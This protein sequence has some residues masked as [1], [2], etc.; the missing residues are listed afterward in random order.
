MRWMLIPAVI[1]L[2]F[3]FGGCASGSTGETVT[4][5][6][7]GNVTEIAFQ[8]ETEK[9]SEISS[10]EMSQTEVE[11]ASESDSE[12]GT[13]KAA[14]EDAESPEG[15]ATETEADTGSSSEEQNSTEKIAGTYTQIS[16]EEAKKMMA[17]S[18]GHVIVDVRRLDEYMEGHIPGAILVTN[19]DI[20]DVP[21]SSLP[22]KDQIILIYCRSGR[23]SKEASQK[24]ADMGYT[25][26][27]EFGGIIDWTGDVTTG[28]EK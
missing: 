22:D 11:N 6:V 1:L 7:T 9:E 4:Q 20:G 16:Q 26:I 27:Y 10:E 8:K 5:P 12:E 2:A 3:L 19:E 13:I 25:A 24:L 21:P 28:M 18:D 23:R 14:K 17:R 15:T